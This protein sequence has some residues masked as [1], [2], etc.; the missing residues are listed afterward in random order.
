MACLGARKLK[1]DFSLITF[2]YSHT[3]STDENE[4]DSED[5]GGMSALE[6]AEECGTAVRE[7]KAYAAMSSLVNYIQP[8]R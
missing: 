7:S 8:V 2:S 3:V 1:T 5:E 6:N 4:E